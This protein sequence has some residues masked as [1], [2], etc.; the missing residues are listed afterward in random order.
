V[1]PRRPLHDPDDGTTA[2]CGARE[3]Q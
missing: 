3:G 2:R 1:I